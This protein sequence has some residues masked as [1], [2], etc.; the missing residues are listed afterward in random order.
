MIKIDVWTDGA[1]SGPKQRGGW[2]AILVHEG[3]IIAYTGYEDQTT[4]NRMELTAVIEGLK[5]VGATAHVTI[6]TDSA[7]VRN[8]LA[9]G[10]LRRWQ[11]NGWKGYKGDDVANQDLWQQ[12]LELLGR[13]EVV[14]KKVKGHTK[15]WSWNT[16]ADRLAV[17]A[18]VNRTSLVTVLDAERAAC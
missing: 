9:Q 13:H 3:T 12:M 16:E 10:W 7:Y 5:A 15:K 14:W 17:E 8:P 18:K 11:A 6:H 1:N 4:S 2:C